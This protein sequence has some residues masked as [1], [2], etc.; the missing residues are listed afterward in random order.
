M[1]KS[2]GRNPVGKSLYDLLSKKDAERWVKL[3]REVIDK[4][5]KIVFE[6]SRVKEREKVKVKF[7]RNTLLPIKLANETYC[8]VISKDITDKA[9]SGDMKQGKK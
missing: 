4:R 3:I 5:K 8:I 2:L 9:V 7:F 1:V 6:D